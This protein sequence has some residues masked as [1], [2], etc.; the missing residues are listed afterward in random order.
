MS[1]T[2]NH[3]RGSKRRPGGE[4]P[5]GG[6]SSVSYKDTDLGSDERNQKFLRLMGAGKKE[7]TGRLG[8]GDYKAV[9]SR[10]TC[11]Q[12]GPA[13]WENADLGNDERK[14]KFLRLMGASKKEHTGRL[15]IGDHKSTSH[16]RS[17]DEDKKINDALEYQFQQSM[18]STMTGRNR[19]H[20]GLGFSEIESPDDKVAALPENVP[21]TEHHYTA[22]G[23]REQLQAEYCSL[24]HSY[25]APAAGWLHAA[26]A[27]RLHA[28]QGRPAASM[29]LRGG[30]LPPCTS[31]AHKLLE[32]L[33]FKCTMIYFFIYTIYIFLYHVLKIESP[34]DKVAALPENVPG[35][36][37]ASMFSNLS[38]SDSD[39][40]SHS[41]SSSESEELKKTTTKE[42]KSVSEEEKESKSSY[43]MKF[44]KSSV[45]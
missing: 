10:P 6:P 29:H 22:R 7:R 23:S 1:S 14:Q 44:V 8:G 20:C 16:F 5:T 34:D 37:P 11:D 26:L 9:N 45:P 4:T 27:G 32:L 41:D 36:E 18:D 35:A 43:K 39:S 28:P 2:E 13:S 31:G 42:S 19:R 12:P 30:R 24:A 40:E 38:S 33:C 25:N 3:P 15:V 21:G 17:G